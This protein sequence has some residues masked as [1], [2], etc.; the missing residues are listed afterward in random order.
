L[1]LGTAKQ[2]VV[3]DELL[4]TRPRKIDFLVAEIKGGERIRLNSIWRDQSESARQRI[5]YI[6][7]WL[8]CIDD[9]DQIARVSGDLQQNFRA[10]F[11]QFSFRVVLFAKRCTPQNL[12]FGMTVITFEDIMRF[13]VTSRA[14]SWIEFG[15]GTRSQHS[16]WSELVNE[17]WTL[18][19][20]E[21]P[22]EIERKIGRMI[23]ALDSANARRE[24]EASMR[25]RGAGHQ[26]SRHQ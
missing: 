4:Q 13:I 15:L 11:G 19:G 16:Q 2:Q 5:E 18:A 24:S 3:R 17:L 12:P 20:P 25:T 1:I 22:V 23:A 6:I 26:D 9:R 21:N 10:E 14:N 8:G 7:R